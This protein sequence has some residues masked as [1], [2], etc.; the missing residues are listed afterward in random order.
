MYLYYFFDLFKIILY[1]FIL[2]S[3]MGFDL[4]YKLMFFVKIRF[5]KYLYLRFGKD[6]IKLLVYDCFVFDKV[7][8]I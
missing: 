8:C 3:I 5:R 4:D 6:L 2:V 1:E 7:L